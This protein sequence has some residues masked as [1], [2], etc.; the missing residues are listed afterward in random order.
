M[1][2]FHVDTVKSHSFKIPVF[3]HK[4]TGYIFVK[5]AHRNVVPM[6]HGQESESISLA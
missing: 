3:V 6:K 5:N 1:T 2:M 4:A